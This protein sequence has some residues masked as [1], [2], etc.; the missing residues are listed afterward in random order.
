MK[1]G[2]VATIVALDPAGP[3]FENS[4]VKNR[5]RK[6]DADYVECIHSNGETLGLFEP[7]CSVD[8]YPNFGFKQPGKLEQLNLQNLSQ[9]I[10][11]KLQSN[12]QMQTEPNM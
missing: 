8:F 5:L 1:K 4:D 3:G 10:Q 12:G 2:R 9:L 6:D 7:I 11:I